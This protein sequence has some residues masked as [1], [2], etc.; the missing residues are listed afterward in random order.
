MT[1]T[2]HQR[3]EWKRPRQV[4]VAP[5]R[6]LTTTILITQKGG[7]VSN[8]SPPLTAEEAALIQQS[9]VLDRLIL[10]ADEDR[11]ELEARRLS[12]LQQIRDSRWRT[13]DEW[14]TGGA[15]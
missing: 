2:T 15:A 1:I 8:S 3:V 4:L 13:W 6:G 5:Y 9:I 10:D 7:A 12:V 14:L 11:E